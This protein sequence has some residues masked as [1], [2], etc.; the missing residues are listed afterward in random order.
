MTLRGR[1]FV[2]VLSALA[3]FGCAPPPAGGDPL[4]FDEAPVSDLASLMAEAPDN[5]TLADESK[6]DE[7]LPRTFD[8][9]ELMTPVRSQGSRGTCTI[10][11]TAA[12]M[13]SLYVA[14]GSMTSPDFSEQF[15]QWS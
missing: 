6:A 1:S 3:L 9:M 14:E 12:L 2:A 15:L 7:V 10:F 8:L 4:T 13:E 5:S 11:A